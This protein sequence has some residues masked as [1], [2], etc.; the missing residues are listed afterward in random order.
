M[1]FL[2]LLFPLGFLIWCRAQGFEK[3]P[4]F[5]LIAFT[6]LFPSAVF[7]AY[8]YF[9]SPFYYLTQD[10]F[11]MNFLYYFL[12]QAFVP[13]AVLTAVFFLMDGKDSV[14][15][16]LSNIFPF[17]AGFYAI[18]IP[19]I[20]LCKDVPYP[21]FALFAKPVMYFFMLTSLPKLCG[22]LFERQRTNVK[23]SKKICSIFALAAAILLPAVIE[24]LWTLGVSVFLTVFLTLAY[25]VFTA[26]FSVIDK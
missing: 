4:K 17:Y 11:L 6:G 18:Y 22:G 2:C 13:L 26:A 5:A 10:S 8:K 24:S 14:Q 23:S 19:F 15:D 20:V 25:V 21:F 9:F 16:R 12:T 7:C 3:F 1:L